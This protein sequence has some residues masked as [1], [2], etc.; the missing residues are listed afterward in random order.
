M[1]WPAHS[2]R[3]PSVLPWPLLVFKLLS[4][5]AETVPF[6]FLEGDRASQSHFAVRHPDHFPIPTPGSSFY[7]N[8][9]PHFQGEQVENDHSVCSHLILHGMMPYKRINPKE[10]SYRTALMN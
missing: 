1:E 2:Q 9:L 8:L 7:P 3:I 10:I 5:A 4:Q 6:H